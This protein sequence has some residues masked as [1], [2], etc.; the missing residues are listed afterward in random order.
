MPRSNTS[1]TLSALKMSRNTTSES[2]NLLVARGNQLHQIILWI[3]GFF[4]IGY[5]VLDFIQGNYDQT[6]M[7]ISVTPIALISYWLYRTGFINASKIINLLGVTVIISLHSFIQTQATLVLA[8]FIP[9]LLSTLIVFQGRDRNIGY[10]LTTIIFFWMIF[11]L[12]S[13]TSIGNPLELSKEELKIEWLI[14]LSGSAIVTIMEVVFILILNRSMQN[15]LLEKTKI[16]DEN[17][18]ILQASIQT[19][20][21]L[22]SIISHDIRGP[23]IM[24][25]SGL[26]MIEWS[27]KLEDEDKAIFEELKKRSNA[28]VSL[29]NNLLVWTRSQTN[30]IKFKPHK[31]STK[32][33]KEI[34]SNFLDFSNYKNIDIKLNIPDQ[35]EVWADANMLEIILRNLFSNAIKFTPSEGTIELGV[36]GKN[37]NVEFYIIDN[38]KGLSDEAK[39]KILQ[40]NPHSTVGT[41]NEKGHGLGLQIVR[42]FIQQHGSELVIHSELNKGSRFSFTLKH[43]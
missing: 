30:Q 15:E 25:N 7:N 39:H 10:I 36:I 17:N 31:L 27:D 6:L 29:I 34:Y 9:I 16:L 22:I 40:G 8:F 18:Q 13:D 26:G 1:G 2:N 20:D 32:E 23:V 11:L 19:K 12:L 5:G 24:V 14:N 38:G 3:T 28:T 35:I 21:K 41:D 33:I 43:H 42:E 4:G 37:N